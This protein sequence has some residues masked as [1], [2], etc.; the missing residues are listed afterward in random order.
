MGLWLL[1]AIVCGLAALAGYTLF[2]TASA[3]SVAFVLA[4]AG[5]AIL[6]IFADTMMP[7]A[8]EH[9]GGL[10]GV[11]TTLGFALGLTR[12]SEPRAE[13]RVSPGKRIYRVHLRRSSKMRKL[14]TTVALVALALPAAA[15]GDDP[16]PS[17]QQSANASCKT[18]RTQMGEAAFK[19]AYGTNANRSNAW[20]KCVS[21]MAGTAKDAAD[22]AAKQCKADLAALGAQA[23][24]AKY[25]DNKNGKNAFGKCV[26]A[27]AQASTQAETQGLVNAAKACKTERAASAAA[28]AAKYGTGNK[29]NAFGR[30]VSA[31]TK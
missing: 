8:F 15:L 24:A 13:R 9:G 11:F 14:L 22:N 1:V 29:S 3:R 30:C 6:T 25:G 28:F 27:K 12:S 2:D 21:A 23:F 18:Q 5:G 26:S 19:L 20:G 7:E 31:K 17:P 16:A 10:V 4:F